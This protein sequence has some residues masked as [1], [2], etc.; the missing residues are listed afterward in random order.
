VEDPDMPGGI[1][2]AAVPEVITGEYSNLMA[3]SFDMEGKV[4]KTNGAP[5]I[6]QGFIVGLQ[7]NLTFET[8]LDSFRVSSENASFSGKVRGLSGST[9]YY[10]AA[11]ATNVAG[12]SYGESKWLKTLSGLGE[13]RTLDP[14]NIKAE[15]VICGGNILDAGEGVITERGV[16]YS[17]SPLTASNTTKTK[18]ASTMTTDSFTCIL[19]NLERETLYYVQA[20][21][22]TEDFGMF[23]GEQKTFTTTSGKVTISSFEIQ[24]I[25]YTNALLHAEI[26]EEGEAPVTLRGFCYAVGIDLPTIDN[27]TIISG[28]GLGEFDG[29]L[30]GLLP[31]TQYYARAYA[32]N[33]YGVAYSEEVLSIVTLNDLPTVQTI[34]A[35][36]AA[37]ASV[38]VE[39]EVLS[40]GI[41]PVVEAGICWAVGVTPNI[42]DHQKIA[43]STGLGAYNGTITGLRGGLTYHI[44]AYA[45][46]DAGTTYGEIIKTIT[47]PVIFAN[48]ATF[49]DGTRIA[50][51]AAYF[52]IQNEAYFLGGDE[53]ASYTDKLW[54]FTPANGF[55]GM[56]AFDDESAWMSAVGVDQTV[57]VLG[58]VVNNQLVNTFCQYL[59][60]NNS[61]SS[62]NIANP[63]T[64][65]ARAMGVLHGGNVY[66]MG[67]IR[68]PGSNQIASNEVWI[69][70]P[71]SAT[72]QQTSAFPEAQYGGVA[73]SHNGTLYAGLGYTSTTTTT[74]SQILRKST[75]N[76]STWQTAKTFSENTGGVQ[77][78]VVH[79]NNLYM[80]DDS[81]FIWCYDLTAGTLQKKTQLAA[82]NR[83]VHCLY[84]IGDLIYIGLGNNTNTL[85][86]YNPVWDNVQP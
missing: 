82:S 15:S 72:W 66:Y 17:T 16:F 57:F 73:F 67:G 83:T 6:H 68:Q 70:N 38:Y 63:P 3:A 53:G 75:D 34:T 13:V 4:T 71:Y 44:R 48:A 56:M 46:N 39:G 7:D 27:D 86:S 62:L 25:G 36:F 31:Y 5:I 35:E 20:Y 55:T 84:S 59:P 29:E 58:G 1:K 40:E 65:V 26:T 10:V 37:G 28:N 33:E 52:M 47:T 43:L 69:F 9:E 12:T 50:G 80:V 49:N 85:I 61:W 14:V 79:Q 32:V 22:N 45:T 8:M 78:G 24:N 76:G 60:Q 41:T 30:N 42:D 11:F 74:R 23:T 51:S 21:A 19:N 81:G 18:V 2:G 64:A 77:A 54:K